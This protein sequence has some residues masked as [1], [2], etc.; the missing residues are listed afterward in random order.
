MNKYV[1][2]S[3]WQCINCCW[4]HRVVV[5]SQFLILFIYSQQMH[6]SGLEQHN[7]AWTTYSEKEDCT[8][9]VAFCGW[10]TDRYHDRH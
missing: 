2:L 7:K 9:W 3:V 4:H 8:G 5:V 6:R 1:P 10:T